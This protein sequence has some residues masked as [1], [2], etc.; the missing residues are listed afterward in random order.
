MPSLRLAL[1]TLFK[2]PFVTAVAVVSLALGIGANAAIFSIFDEMLLR[3][4]PVAHPDELI[5]LAAPG[6]KPGSTSCG[7]AGE[8]D[9][10]LSYPM[11]RDLER[12]QS[13][14]TGLAAHR[15]FGANI[16]FHGQTISTEGLL[17]SGSYFPVLGIQP[18]AGRLLTP[19]DDQAIGAGAVAV[20]GY[21]YWQSSL[22]GDPSVVGQTILVNGHPFA[23][24]GVGPKDFDG[25]TLGSQPDL[26]IPITMRGVVDTH[27]QAF[28]NRKSYWVYAFGRL[29]PGV[30]LDQARSA[31]NG[32][33]HPIIQDV[34]APLQQGMSEATMAQFKAKPLVVS[35]GRRGQ[36]SLDKNARTPLALLFG[37]TGIV[38]L[39]A[40]ANIANLLLVRA[41][42]REMEMA[43]RLSLGARR[44]QIVAQLLAESVLLALMGGVAS[45]AVARVT[46][47]AIA[48][49]MPPSAASAL[50][51]Q[52]HASVL[53]FAAALS[54]ATGIAFGLFPALQSTR[55][56]LVTALRNNS[57]KLSGTRGAA[58][59]RT[60]L[61]T[62]QISLSMALLISAGL[63]IRSLANVSRVDLGFRTERLVTFGVSPEL[64]GYTPDRSQVFF[65]RATDELAAIPGVT[66]VTAALVP[67]VANSNWGNDVHVEGFHRDADTDADS[68]YNVVGPDYFH[69]IG[70]PLL[71]GR[72]FTAADAAGA[73]R[74][75]VVNEAFARKFGLGRDAVGKHMS[76]RSDSL[77]IEIVGLV[78]DAKY[79]DV[80]RPVPPVFFL[81][82][83][84]DKTLGSLQFYVRTS[85]NV[86]PVLRSIPT[87]MKKLDATL[88]VENLKTLEQQVR[89]NVFLD[90]MIGMLSSAFA[91]LA[92]LLAAVGLYGVLAYTVAQ[93]TREIGVRMALGADAGSVRALVLRQVAVMTAIGGFIGILGAVGL[94]R[95]AQSILFELKGYDP[96]VLVLSAAMLTLVA[97]GA[98]YIPALRASRVD[99]MQAL[100]YE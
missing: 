67:L 31:L 40:C 20:L 97:F 39:I 78:K 83:R 49:M 61:V 5:N 13:V 41:T 80:K 54:F 85:G 100:R 89:E 16:A 27:F 96:P 1:R 50:H 4:L 68:R 62:A 73:P 71:A 29:K 14:L 77:D 99:P 59:F 35:E 32:I 70:M 6:P 44:A 23:I 7:Q 53:W 94:G 34:E 9:V 36:T 30:T 21:A 63:F 82:Y 43:V 8:C 90:R 65:A 19:N 42:G 72:D 55:P 38:L 12:Q 45:I 64:N 76:D 81:P 25:T 75:A 57:G 46:L 48:S 26:F 87:V 24:V 2:S 15:G 17:V 95:A 84:Q 22:G 88:P 98:G 51:L 18:A 58:R 28:E 56:D 11:Y 86:E 3:P 10:V 74:V 60:S 52:L 47:V 66:G 33:Y 93:R 91:L 37:T 69:V 92:T 79:S